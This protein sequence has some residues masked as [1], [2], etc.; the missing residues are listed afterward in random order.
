MAV[1][2]STG[3]LVV[4]GG[5]GIGGNTFVGGNTNVGGNLYVTGNAYIYGNTFLAGN[6]VGLG[7]AR[8]NGLLSAL[9]FNAASDYRIKG[10][11]E[12]LSNRYNVDTLRPVKY[13]N[14]LLNRDDIGVIAHELQETY[15]FLVEGNKD[16]EQYQSVN[17]MGL[18]GII[19]KEIQDL[20]K[21]VKNIKNTISSLQSV[22][23]LAI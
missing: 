16:E 10:N 20:K 19:V 21:E 3:G 8:F 12:V 23:P 2:P 13:F 14:K 17:Y 15:P 4:T 22:K 11:V 1:S 6:L 7:T 9:A 5:V 18:I